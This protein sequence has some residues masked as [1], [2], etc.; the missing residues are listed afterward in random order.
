MKIDDQELV[1]LV[2]EGIT[3][4][5]LCLH[6]LVSRQAIHQRAKKLGIDGGIKRP[7]K[8]PKPPSAASLKYSMPDHVIKPLVKSGVT[9]LYVRQ[10]N[11]AKQRGIDWH[12][13]FSEWWAIWTDSGKW[14]E[15][16]RSRGKY[17]MAR[18]RDNGPYAVGNVFICTHSQNLADASMWRQEKS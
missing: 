5:Q 18:E 4:R 3:Y 12:L 1:R 10:R 9:R 13:S 11:T 7:P 17:V 8:K 16:G 2:N 15:R 6:F 14:N